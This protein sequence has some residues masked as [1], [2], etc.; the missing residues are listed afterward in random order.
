MTGTEKVRL[1][2]QHGEEHG[3]NRC[4]EAIGLRPRDY[5]GASHLPATALPATALPA[6]AGSF[7]NLRSRPASRSTMSGSGGFVAGMSWDCP[8]DLQTQPFPCGGNS[9][10]AAGQLNLGAG[11]DP[12]PLEAFATDFTGRTYAGGNRKAYLMA[13]IDLE[14][15][16]V[17]GWR[18]APAPIES[19]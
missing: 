19:W 2:D 13:V 8:A 15:K 6:T 17:P 18:S 11:Q 16:Y 3:L 9:R 10:G 12:G 7:Q 1:V 14:S 4:I 5:L